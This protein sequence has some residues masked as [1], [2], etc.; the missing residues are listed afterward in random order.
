MTHAF[1]FTHPLR[2]TRALSFTHALNFT[3]ALRFTHALSA[4]LQSWA[5]SNSGCGVQDFEHKSDVLF[6][7]VLSPWELLKVSDLCNTHLMRFSPLRFVWSKPSGVLLRISKRY[8]TAAWLWVCLRGT[9]TELGSNLLRFSGTSLVPDDLSI[10]PNR[11]RK[12]DFFQR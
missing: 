1:S 8:L 11:K 12:C 3:H 7:S 4:K 10:G 9:S 6:L 5:S 2:F